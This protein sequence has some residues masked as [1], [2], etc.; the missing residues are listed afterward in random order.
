MLLTEWD[1][2]EAK[3][4][5]YEEGLEDGLEKGREEGREEAWEKAWEAQKERD[6]AIVHNAL[7]KG[8]PYDTIS[9]ITGLDIE[10]VKRLAAQ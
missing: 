8:F 5:W 10:T 2:E 4:V 9:E 6:T 1:T 3:E 7:A